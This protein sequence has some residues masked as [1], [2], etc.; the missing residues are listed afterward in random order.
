MPNTNA[1]KNNR[2]YNP[3]PIKGLT[4][5]HKWGTT[6]TDKETQCGAY[7]LTTHKEIKQSTA[8]TNIYESNNNNY[9]HTFRNT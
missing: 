5:L 3:Y 2:Y 6:T 4:L 1:H 7:N 8:S 9:Q